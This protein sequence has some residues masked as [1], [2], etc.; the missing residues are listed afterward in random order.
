MIMPD[1][2]LPFTWPGENAI[3]KLTE[4]AAGLFI[5]AKTAIGHY[6]RAS[7]CT[8]YSP[9]YL[10]PSR[11]MGIPAPL[12]LHIDPELEPENE[13]VPA[14]EPVHDPQALLYPLIPKRRGK[15]ERP[16]PRVPPLFFRALLDMSAVDSETR[17]SRSPSLAAPEI[18]RR[19]LTWFCDC[20]AVVPRHARTIISLRTIRIPHCTRYG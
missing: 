15:K 1:I 6:P 3:E 2:A 17:R 7:N 20:C 8:L 11:H 16:V 9:L 12:I 19:I 10:V 4:R 14:V 5:W 13:Q 18:R